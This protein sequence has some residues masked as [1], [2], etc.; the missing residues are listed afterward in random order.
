MPLRLEYRLTHRGGV[1]FPPDQTRASRGQVVTLV[2][3]RCTH[4][5]IP[6]A[7]RQVAG[8]PSD[9]WDRPADLVLS[10]ARD[11]PGMRNAVREAIA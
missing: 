11:D 8:V 10:P 4:S 2:P 9:R 6:S 3:E 7:Y 1:L 5:S